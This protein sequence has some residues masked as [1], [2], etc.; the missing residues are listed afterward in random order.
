MDCAKTNRIAVSIL[1]CLIIAG[2]VIYLVY[3]KIK[4]Q[5]QSKVEVAVQN[6]P[7]QAQG[8]HVRTRIQRP[9]H[10][11][12]PLPQLNL[13]HLDGTPLNLSDY[14]GKIVL[15]HIWSTTA[16]FSL[17]DFNYLKP[18]HD[19]FL[20]DPRLVMLGVC[21]EGD[22]ATIKRIVDGTQIGWAQAMAAPDAPAAT[23]V[24]LATPGLVILG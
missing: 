18:I 13:L 11:S 17:Q 1:I 3:D 15:V 9:D 23:K 22:A 12:E 24:F 16:P 6:A 2:T 21:A 4:P 7:Q 20:L 10:P 5:K 8:N 14:S 19:K